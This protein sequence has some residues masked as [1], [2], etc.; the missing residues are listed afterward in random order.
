MIL[1]APS[2]LSFSIITKGSFRTSLLKKVDK[3]M[4][5]AYH[6]HVDELQNYNTLSFSVLI[7]VINI[8]DLD[9]S[10]VVMLFSKCHVHTISNKSIETS[11]LVYPCEHFN[12]ACEHGKDYEK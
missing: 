4:Y 7:Y 9:G 12:F 5:E 2:K 6:V 8:G 11:I 10:H 1:S 3:E